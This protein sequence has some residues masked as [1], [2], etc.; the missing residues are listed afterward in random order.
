MKNKYQR[1]TKE[2][3]KEAI[4]RYK[5]VDE[6]KHLYN[7]L[8][9]LI[10]TCLIAALFGVGVIIY[11]VITNDKWYYIAEYGFMIVFCVV[12]VTFCKTTLEKKYNEFLIKEMKSE[13]DKKEDKKSKNKSK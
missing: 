8:T 5:E 10:Y 11:L 9:R 2:E 6:N 12:L 3:K 4:K 1:L 7:K 13:K